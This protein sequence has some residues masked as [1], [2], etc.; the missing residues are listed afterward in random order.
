M[1]GFD[2]LPLCSWDRE[3]VKGSWQLYGQEDKLI[4]LKVSNTQAQM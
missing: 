4:S 1:P 3:M 2:L